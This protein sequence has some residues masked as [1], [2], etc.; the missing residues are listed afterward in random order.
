MFVPKIPRS[1]ASPKACWRSNNRNRTL[2]AHRAEYSRHVV[3]PNLSLRRT[4]RRRRLRAVRSA[5]VSLARQGGSCATHL[6]P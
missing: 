5:P 1:G 2:A 4:A 6:T 3:T